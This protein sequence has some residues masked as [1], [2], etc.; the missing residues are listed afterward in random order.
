MQGQCAS[1]PRLAMQEFVGRERMELMA[2][3]P[4][5]RWWC[6]VVDVGAALKFGD[7]ET[8]SACGCPSALCSRRAGVRAAS[9]LALR[10]ENGRLEEEEE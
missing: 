2:H 10:E 3:G 7:M 5:R 4:G 9:P 1:L 8:T 6:R